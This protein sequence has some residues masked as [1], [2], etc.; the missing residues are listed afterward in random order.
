MLKAHK[1]TLELASEVFKKML[2]RCSKEGKT[3]QIELPEDDP[4]AL[5]T[6]L[7]IAHFIPV[8]DCPEP[9]EIHEIAVLID[10]YNFVCMGPSLSSWHYRSTSKM[11]AEETVYWLEAASALGDDVMFQELTKRLVLG[12]T[13]SLVG[14]LDAD[15]V[16]PASLPFKLEEQR[17]A[18]RSAVQEL[19]F[20]MVVG[21]RG[22]SEDCM[23]HNRETII[24]YL[25]EHELVPKAVQSRALQGIF[26]DLRKL[27]HLHLQGEM[28]PLGRH[29]CQNLKADNGKHHWST[30]IRK[31][32]DMSRKV[33]TLL[34]GLD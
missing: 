28:S 34:T 33:G 11:T 30:R 17:T 32:V 2:Q 10:K 1:G 25:K 7:D 26:D 16:F 14:F 5:S 22:C 27:L 8:Q 23:V 13:E 24:K 3:K 15:S 18:C 31:V 19:V 29:R 9:K 4:I 12:H 6:I 20:E 21:F